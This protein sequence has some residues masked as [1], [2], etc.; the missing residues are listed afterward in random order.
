MT[1]PTLTPPEQLLEE[2][3]K[4]MV[5]HPDRL[6]VDSMITDHTATFEVQC[7]DSDVGKVL[8]RRGAHANALRTLFSAV[9]GKYR[10]KLTLVVVEPPKPR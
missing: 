7:H 1:S 9:Y 10:K 6:K 8:G 5:D 2:I 4:Q 3:L